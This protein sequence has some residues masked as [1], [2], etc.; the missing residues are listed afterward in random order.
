MPLPSDPTV[1]VKQGILIDKFIAYIDINRKRSRID[2]E[3]K[4][5]TI[6]SSTT[7]TAAEKSD[8]IS[9]YQELI[10]KSQP[11]TEEEKSNYK[12]GLCYGFSVVH[13]YMNA[14][15]KL[16]WWKELLSTLSQ[17]DGDEALLQTKTNL[18]GSESTDET[19]DSLFQRAASYVLFNFAGNYINEIIGSNQTDF[20]TEKSLFETEH[21]EKIKN[22]CH[23]IASGHFSKHNL[24]QLL[25][26]TTFSSK[27]ICLIHSLTH[28]CAIHFDSKEKKWFFYDPNSREG[29]KEFS[30]KT[31]LIQT[32]QRT[33]GK[34][35]AVEV[36]SWDKYQAEK[37]KL[38]ADTY[39]KIVKTNPDELVAEKGLLFLVEH[40]DLLSSIFTKA[41]TDKSLAFTIAT[42][43]TEEHAG[44]S[45][46]TIIEANAQ[47]AYQNLLILSEASA[48]IN[49][50]LHYNLLHKFSD[51][52]KEQFSYFAMT[53][54]LSPDI[55]VNALKSLPETELKKFVTEY[56]SFTDPNIRKLF[57]ECTANLNNAFTESKYS[58]II[59]ELK[60]FNAPVALWEKVLIRLT[61]NDI[62]NSEDKI[63]LYATANENMSST[64]MPEYALLQKKIAILERVEDYIKTRLNE[65]LFSRKIKTKDIGFFK[66]EGSQKVTEAKIKDAE[67]LKI[68]ILNCKTP[69]EL[70]SAIQNSIKQNNA[71]SGWVHR[72]GE[73]GKC[74]DDCKNLAQIETQPSVSPKK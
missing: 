14:T 24:E 46:S 43:L 59:T 39:N 57:I 12:K 74:L 53:E 9:I 66:T 73:Y 11:L 44:K 31:K 45:I 63:K 68:A 58:A 10:K 25:N 22:E 72:K 70:E 32:I 61:E 13:S 69:N 37:I 27:S 47:N 64:D 62:I 48:P 33:L 40:P 55:V 54:N 49:M 8:Q 41:K 30:D 19:Y 6:E 34:S 35:L 15:E 21:G 71:I 18:I 51:S 50:A 42:A 65:K 5:K 17:W 38:F 52:H 60:K 16:A 36:A 26:E 56:Q 67:Q 29:E 20:L 28:T 3:N 4:I 2:A 1:S 23:A 7:Q